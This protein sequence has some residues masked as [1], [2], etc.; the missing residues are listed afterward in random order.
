MNGNTGYIFYDRYYHQ[1]SDGDWD[2]I[3][4]KDHNKVVLSNEAEASIE[5]VNKTLEETGF[6]QTYGCFAEFGKHSFS[7]K[8]MNPG[9]LI[10]SGYLHSAGVKEEYKIGYFC[11]HTTGW[12]VI[13]G[14]SIKGVLRSVFPKASDPCRAQKKEYIEDVLKLTKVDIDALDKAIFVGIQDGDRLPIGKRDIFF[15][16]HVDASQNSEATLFGHDAI[17]PHGDDILKNPNP[18]KFLKVLPGVVFKFQFDLK[19]SGSISADQKKTLFK[20][21][22]L[23]FGVGAKTNIGYGQFEDV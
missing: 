15:D 22:L 4:C 5:R 8:T 19:P 17:T 20:T 12:P 3:L 11:D 2:K 16:A 21:I 7:L 13:P 6:D 14:S 9:L 10:G 18:I 23:D 1:F